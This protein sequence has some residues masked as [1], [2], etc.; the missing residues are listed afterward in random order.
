MQLLLRHNWPGNTEQLWQVLK[1]VVQRR[2]A[3]VIMPK[4]LPPSAGP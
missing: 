3:G 4:D 2:R 1:Q